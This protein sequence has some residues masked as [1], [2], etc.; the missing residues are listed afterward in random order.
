M[1]L[2]D[3]VD[4]YK[5]VINVLHLGI[6]VSVCFNIDEVERGFNRS[7]CVG[8]VKV[9]DSITFQFKKESDEWIHFENSNYEFML[10]IKKGSK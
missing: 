10:S 5:S 9:D 7:T 6:G 8:G 3:V 1:N 2:Y 4:E